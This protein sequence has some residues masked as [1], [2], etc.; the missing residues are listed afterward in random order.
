MRSVVL[1]MT[2][3]KISLNNHKFKGSGMGSVLL[4][5]GGS[6]SGSSYDGW[7]DYQKTT[8]TNMVNLFDRVDEYLEKVKDLPKKGLRMNGAGL[9]EI[10]QKLEKLIIKSSRPRKEKNINFNL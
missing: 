5:N 1:P 7:E 6:G 9:S 8:G 10:N 2:N 3:K 4:R